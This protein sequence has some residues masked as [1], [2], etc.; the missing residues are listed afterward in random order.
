MEHKFPGAFLSKHHIINE[1]L[2]IN[3]LKGWGIEIQVDGLDSNPHLTSRKTFFTSM[4]L[5][6]PA[7]KALGNP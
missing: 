6:T 7:G 2:F 3:R 1:E 4:N 5:S